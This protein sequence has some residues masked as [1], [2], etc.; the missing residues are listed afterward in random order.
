MLLGKP[1]RHILELED[2]RT[3]SIINQ[4][5]PGG[6]GIGMHEDITDLR[7]AEAQIRHMAR[8]DALTD[9][10]NRVMFKERIEDALRHVSREKQVAILCLDLDQFKSV[11][12][13]LGHPI[14]DAL[15][16]SVADRLR[17]TLR[18]T[19][20]VARFG[21]DEFAVVQSSAE[22]PHDA[23]ALA[24]RLID[25]LCVPYDVAGHQVSSA[26]ASHRVAPVDGDEPEHS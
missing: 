9:L 22:Q 2:G 15:L 18:E 19:D 8:H 3:L 7:R 4:P 21:G 14:G 25:A 6:G 10:P 26:S 11:N 23:T 1:S 12:D 17:A 24:Q 5:L 20:S 16:K 13:T